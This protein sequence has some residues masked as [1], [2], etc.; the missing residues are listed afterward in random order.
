MAIQKKKSFAEGRRVGSD[1][2]NPNMIII[3]SMLLEA[4]EKNLYPLENKG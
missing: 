2:K 1:S 3:F 4:T